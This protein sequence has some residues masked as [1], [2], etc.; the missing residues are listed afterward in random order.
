MAKPNL[1]S[2]LRHLEIT[3]QGFQGLEQV[4]S[5][6]N[7]SAQD[8]SKAMVPLNF[9]FERYLADL[10]DIA[11]GGDT[12]PGARGSVALSVVSKEPG[13]EETDTSDES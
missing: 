9:E 3:L 12:R 13:S 10:K 7:A 5:Q 1:Y 4:S 2:L 11:T 8:V 6:S